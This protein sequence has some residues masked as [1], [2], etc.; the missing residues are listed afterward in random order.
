[1]HEC[2]H[3]GLHSQKYVFWAPCAQ[4]VDEGLHELTGSVHTVY[5]GMVVGAG[6]G[7]T[8]VGVDVDGA[9]VATGHVEAIM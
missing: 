5:V 6:D 4:Y 9:A 7:R 2:T 3:P 8:V 1:M